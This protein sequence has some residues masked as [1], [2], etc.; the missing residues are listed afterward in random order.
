MGK[1][2]LTEKIKMDLKI[3]PLTA[4]ESDD[5]YEKVGEMFVD[6]YRIME[7]KGLTYRL[8]R[9]GESIWLNSIKSTL[10]KLNQVYLALDGERIIAFMSA[11]IRLN[12]LYLGGDK[13]GY[14]SLLYV[15][16]D[17]R[18]SQV[19]QILFR[20]MEEWFQFK[21]VERIELEALA[22][23]EPGLNICRKLGYKDDIIRMYKK[24]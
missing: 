4:H 16:D 10:G 22:G 14:A 6:L 17:Y 7:S 13:V 18:K 5:V 8:A 3:R 20:K 1:Y 19:G 11:N 15:D 21:E 23:N 2:L 9:N 12:P 24:I